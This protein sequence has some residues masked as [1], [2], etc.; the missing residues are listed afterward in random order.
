MLLDPILAAHDQLSPQCVFLG[1]PPMN[2]GIQIHTFLGR[3]CADR[4]I[5]LHIFGQFW[6]I[7]DL[8]ATFVYESRTYEFRHNVLR[9]FAKNT[10]LI[11]CTIHSL[12][13]RH[14]GWFQLRF[15]ILSLDFFQTRCFFHNGCFTSKNKRQRLKWL[16][17]MRWRVQLRM[18]QLIYEERRLTHFIACNLTCAPLCSVSLFVLRRCLCKLFLFSRFPFKISKST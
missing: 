3:F 11:R 17:C 8:I 5:R 14:F 15:V 18:S 2:R 7:L 6:G 1:R 16:L 9:N 4:N 12:V 13:L 10:N